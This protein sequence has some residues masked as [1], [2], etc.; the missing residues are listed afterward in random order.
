MMLCRCSTSEI[1]WLLADPDVLMET[2]SEPNADDAPLPDA[3]PVVSR[4]RI[5]LM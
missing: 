4:F 3:L 2:V 5:W 1:N